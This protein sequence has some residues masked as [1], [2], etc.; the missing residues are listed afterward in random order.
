[1]DDIKTWSKLPV[2]ASAR[3]TTKAKYKDIYN[4][5]KSNDDQNL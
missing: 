1:M 4:D 5:K 2:E 3:K